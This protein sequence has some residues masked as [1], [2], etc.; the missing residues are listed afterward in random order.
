M[1]ILKKYTNVT[2]AVLGTVEISVNKIIKQTLAPT[3]INEK[4]PPS[5]NTLF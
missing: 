4:T 5:M 3:P 1:L 2:D